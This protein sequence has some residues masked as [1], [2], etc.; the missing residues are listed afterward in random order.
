MI[1]TQI[2]LPDALYR[3][4]K[5]IAKE[6]EMSLAELLRRG[7]EYMTNVCPPTSV[8]QDEWKL[9]E[10]RPLGGRDP[11][12]DEGWRETIHMSSAPTRR[13]AEHKVP[14][15]DRREKA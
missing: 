10:P 4:L 8:K 13:V 12:A 3:L 7:A 9:P 6:R 5:R 1:K 15:P 2:Q 14:W 11:F